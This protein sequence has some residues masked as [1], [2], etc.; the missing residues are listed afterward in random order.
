MCDLAF[1]KLEKI[2]QSGINEAFVPMRPV[3]TNFFCGRAKEVARIVTDIMKPGAHVLLYGDRGVGKTSLAVHACDQLLNHRYID[4]FFVVR[5][6]GQDSFSS[7]SRN[8][9]DQLGIHQ[10]S[11]RASTTNFQGGIPAIKGGHSTST[12][13]EVY[14][15][16]SS[17]EWVARELTDKNIV[18]IID[19]FDTIKD[20]NEKAK[21]S[22]LIKNLSDSGSRLSLLIVGIAMTAAELVEGHLSA[23]RSLTEV[24]LDRMSADELLDIIKKGEDRTELFFEPEVKK[25]IVHSSFGFPYFTHL[26]ALKSAE[27]AVVSESKTVTM[28]ML[29]NGLKKALDDNLAAFKDKY[30]GAIGSNERKRKVIYCC[31]LL[32]KEVFS[33]SSLRK[34]YEEIFGEKIESIS[35]SNAIAKA[36]S[37][38]TDT[39]LRRKKQGFY[40]FNDPRMPVYI[41]LRHERNCEQG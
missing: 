2:R 14:Y 9:F 41:V 26:L 15:D 18:I 11:K 19:E 10:V 33:A 21:F 35:V 20:T 7:I 5:C 16:Y 32:G 36:M 37:D 8:I 22:W 28:E 30:D 24:K 12:E 6:S 4:S 17:P 27:E 29:D 1:D 34:K 38:T 40:Y 23:S 31:A 13:E 25:L 39:I 3:S